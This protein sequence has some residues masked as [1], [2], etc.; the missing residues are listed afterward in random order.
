[1]KQTVL[2]GVVAIEAKAAKRVAEAKQQAGRARERVKAEL[3]ALARQLDEEAKRKTADYQA[4]AEKK[5][6]A[7]LAALDR[8]LAEAQA[9]LERARH[10]RAP[11]AVSEILALLEQRADG[12]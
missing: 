10:E 3:D 7:A 9:A 4:E 12:D 5:K 6:A 1:M 11:A 2:D 8:R